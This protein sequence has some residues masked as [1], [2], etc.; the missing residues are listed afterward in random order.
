MITKLF[1]WI[2][3]GTALCCFGLLMSIQDIGQHSLLAAGALA[4]VAWGTIITAAKPY[5]MP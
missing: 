4:L 3:R 2:H 5:F 1:R